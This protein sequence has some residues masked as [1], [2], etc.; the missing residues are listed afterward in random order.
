MDG[1]DG[2]GLVNEQTVTAH[3]LWLN[4][5]NYS[6]GRH[7]KLLVFFRRFVSWLWF[8]KQMDELPRNLKLKG[9]RK[10]KVHKEVKRF[11]GVK[12]VLAGLPEE[13]RLWAMLGLNCG[14]TNADLGE[15]TWKQIDQSRW[16]LTRR[17][18]K[19]GQTPTIPTVT[20]KLWPETVTPLTRLPTRSGLLFFTKRETPLY[21]SRFDPDGK[22][23]KKDLFATYWN[24]LDPKP[25]I[26]LGKF[27]SIAA[28]A[29]K[30]N[31]VFRQYEDYT[32]RG[33]D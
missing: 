23:R 4:A 17:R 22:V 10:K 21:E 26:S 15:T 13:N 1:G 29:L 7:N 16:T 25:G 2:R 9:H 20:Y 8:Q 12:R 18:V 27:R 14:M 19:T 24:K 30:K 31:A 5:K 28:T 32:P 33:S 11:V 6:A 3:H